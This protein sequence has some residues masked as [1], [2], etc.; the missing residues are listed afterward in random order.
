MA[1]GEKG[2]KNGK[3]EVGTVIKGKDLKGK[4]LC[5]IFSEDMKMRGFQ[6]MMK[7]LYVKDADFTEGY[8]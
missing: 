8:E 3:F 6:Y 7:Y 2:M 1:K 5:K 4:I